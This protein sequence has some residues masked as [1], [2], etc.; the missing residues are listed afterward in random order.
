M[1]S[2]FFASLTPASR[3]LEVG[4]WSGRL[5]ERILKH[6][7][8]LPENYEMADLKYA[9]PR[10]FMRRW[11]HGLVKSGKIKLIPGNIF[12]KILPENYYEHILIPES[13]FPSE[14][15]PKRFEALRAEKGP[16][17]AAIAMLVALALRLYPSLRQGGSLRISS[18]HFT[19]GKIH[20]NPEL[21]R[22]L[23]QFQFA[24]TKSGL[25]LIKK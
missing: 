5:A 13:F 9:G 18:V 1:D 15:E 21:P 10:P 6:S 14:L 25:I 4:S 3:V 24:T 19:I 20:L 22:L 17:E 11:I 2:G 16:K 12:H 7:N 23:P 8:M